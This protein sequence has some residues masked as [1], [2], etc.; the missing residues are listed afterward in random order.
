L[1]S[2]GDWSESFLMRITSLFLVPSMLAVCACG[3]SS[4]PIIDAGLDAPSAVTIPQVQSIAMAPGTPVILAAV[5]VTAVGEYGARTGDVWVEEPGGGPQSGIH[6]YGAQPTVVMALHP[7][8]VV[9]VSNAVKGTFAAPTDT[10]GRTEVELE[11]PTTDQTITVTTVG[12]APLPAVSTVGA[13]AIGMMQDPSRSDQW[14]MWDG[15]LVEVTNVTE[16][17]AVAEALTSSTPDPTLQEFGITGVASVESALAPFPTGL[18]YGTCLASVTGVVEYY[19]GYEILPV[20]TTDV[21]GDGTSCPTP[22]DTI[23]LCTDGIDNDG[24][25]LT[26]C[27][28][29][30][31]IINDGTCRTMVTIAAIDGAVDAAP[32]MPV[33]PMGAPTGV[34]LGDGSAAD[35]YITA[36]ECPGASGSGSAVPCQD[37]WV[38][39]NPSAGS[40]GGLYVHAVAPPLISSGDIG[41]TVQLVGSLEAFD[42]DTAGET[43]PELDAL[44]VITKST[45]VSTIAPLAGQT[46]AALT[47]TATGRPYVGSLVTLA[48]VKLVSAP[49]PQSANDATLQQGSTMFEA[50]ADI[51]V[52]TSAVGTCF[53]SITGIWTYDVY[54]HVYSLEPTVEGIVA[55][56][57]SFC[58]S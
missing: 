45:G 37:F 11:P 42:N 53:S 13:L 12:T 23:A 2:F 9:D 27:E 5:V 21:V 33:L 8:D 34:Q 41:K 14:R 39:T 50:Q 25:G 20:A 31:C 17:S 43:L 30:G 55:A 26:D 57:P 44:A 36:A 49:N 24:N 58:S 10:S 38:A 46:A 48:N 28:D 3:H 1:P 6:L 22:E 47:A 56:N 32:T 51:Y 54:N 15:V 40:D 19:S 29:N 4:N 35:V 18:S 52:L 7:G 16:T